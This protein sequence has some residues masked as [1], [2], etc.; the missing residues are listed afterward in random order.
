M[1]RQFASVGTLQTCNQKDLM[2]LHRQALGGIN[3]ERHV[4][5]YLQ[6]L[7]FHSSG[8]RKPEMF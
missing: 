1:S 7:R 6:R 4:L 3:L 8:K 2:V 5:V